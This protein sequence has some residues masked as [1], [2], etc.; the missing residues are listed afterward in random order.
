M[1]SFLSVNF[2]S[3]GLFSKNKI[4]GKV[5]LDSEGWTSWLDR[6]N[7][8]G[9]GDYETLTDFIN[10]G[11]SC[12]NPSKVEWKTV[13]G[14]K[15]SSQN[16][17]VD[18]SFG[19]YCLN[20]ENPSGCKDYEV[21]FYCGV[22]EPA[23]NIC[24]DSDGGWNYYVKGEVKN[25]EN[26]VTD[27][28][29]KY[30]GILEEYAC[31]DANGN[32][33]MRDI[34]CDNGCVD[35]A[36]VLPTNEYSSCVD[37]FEEDQNCVLYVGEKAKL[38]SDEVPLFIDEITST[39]VT[40]R[41][42]EE[43]ATTA[44]FGIKELKEGDSWVLGDGEIILIV[45]EILFYSTGG[46][47][48]GVVLYAKSKSNIECSSNIDCPKG[49]E[50][51]NSFC[52]NVIPYSLFRNSEWECYDGL[53]SSQGG[54]TSCKSSE[55][56]RSYAQ[57]FC[58]G[59]C[60]DDGSK[61]GINSFSVSNECPGYSECSSNIDCPQYY[62]CVND[63]CTENNLIELKT[64]EE[65]AGLICEYP[66]QCNGNEVYALD[67]K[68]CVGDC[69]I[70]EKKE[71]PDKVYYGDNSYCYDNSDKT[72]CLLYLGDSIYPEDYTEDNAPFVINIEGFRISD[73]GYPETPVIFNIKTGDG[74][75]QKV[76]LSKSEYYSFESHQYVGFADKI[77]LS[78]EG[79][80]KIIDSGDYAAVI[81]LKSQSVFDLGNENNSCSPNECSLNGKCYILGYRKDGRFCSES[82]EFEEQLSEEGAVCD[83]SFECSTNLCIDG[84]CISQGLLQ[85][86]FQ[87]FRKVF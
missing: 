20:S 49:Y 73:E 18:K 42:N 4:T 62:S 45:K 40:L 54:P 26:S 78:F 74:E 75:E 83:N 9:N 44:P 30:S 51:A 76:S 24:A 23:E 1:L 72:I 13:N 84:E 15:F 16:L 8:S 28:C 17:H 87:W 19:F 7:P 6:D 22:D 65:L 5:T 63:F 47:R 21:R 86:I 60:N 10:S 2:V 66:E 68:C 77:T 52:V 29:N 67:A 57:D 69:Q 85:K 71:E 37:G 41:L 34:K 55:L 64:C 82:G 61:C 56:W 38:G 39:I 31:D 53:T 12:E 70:P 80:E 59:H 43:G 32:I 81:T 46:L 79:L 27:L 58:E 33:L 35:G 48:N 14:E 25:N 3:A 11:Q 50:C 36:C